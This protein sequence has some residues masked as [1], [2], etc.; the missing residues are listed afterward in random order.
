[1]KIF[2]LSLAFLVL[3]SQRAFADLGLAWNP[4]I[5]LSDRFFTNGSFI[6]PNELY[7]QEAIPLLQTVAPGQA[8]LSVGTERGLMGAIAARAGAV[9]LIDWDPNVVLYNQINTSLLKSSKNR[10]DY[11]VLRLSATSD[12]WQKRDRGA[13]ILSDRRAWAWWNQAVRK[14]DRFELFHA[15]FRSTDGDVPFGEL[16]YLENTGAYELISRLAKA[17][18]IE[19]AYSSIQDSRTLSLISSYLMRAG[20]TVGVVDI[21]NILPPFGLAVAELIQIASRLKGSSSQDSII[22]M[23]DFA[24]TK[25]SGRAGYF[26]YRFSYILDSVEEGPAKESVPWRVRKLEE[27]F[28][29]DVFSL[30]DGSSRCIQGLGKLNVGNR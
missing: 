22:L 21:S 19:T 14:S 29:P 24:M 18:L 2:F 1:M 10:K 4:D 6:Y 27:G 17:G 16:N 30:D 25:G 15:D 11:V 28:R 8:Y 23:Q 26:A 5:V 9:F 20:K 12:Q 7:P 13:S 3:G